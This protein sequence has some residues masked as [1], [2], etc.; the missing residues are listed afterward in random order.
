ML[1]EIEVPSDAHAAA[2]EQWLNELFERELATDG[3][4]AASQQQS[5]QLWTYRER[6][7]ESLTKAGFVHKNDVSVPVGRLAD[8]VDDM[9]S[10]F[11]S[12]YPD[13]EIYFFG[14]VGDGNL[15]VNIMKPAA[16][17]VPEFLD[18]CHGTDEVLFE[19]INQH[20]G[21]I[22]AEHGIGLLKKP[23]LSYSRSAAELALFRR[24]KEAFDPKGLLNPGKIFDLAPVAK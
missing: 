1:V 6:I 18:Q 23:F 8:F 3:V 20:R 12:R 13:F 9:H 11:A 22:S 14:H 21:S 4:L 19:L 24:V 15:H 7:S 17:A 2:A 10:A 5:E 16:M